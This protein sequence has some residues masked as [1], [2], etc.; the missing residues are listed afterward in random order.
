VSVQER[1]IL[2][3]PFCDN[4]PISVERLKPIVAELERRGVTFTHPQHRIASIRCECR[5]LSG[6]KQV[7]V[8]TQ[9]RPLAENA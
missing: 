2:Y 9:S 4:P 6:L 7:C 1:L 5:R 3:R 8:F